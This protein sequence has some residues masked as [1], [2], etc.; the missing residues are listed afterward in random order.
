MKIDELK[1]LAKSFTFAVRGVKNCIVSER[2]MRIHI[3]VAFFTLLFSLF[4]HFSKA[5]MILL[6]LTIAGVISCEMMNTALEAVVDL[7]EPSYNK[8]AQVAKDIAAGAVLVSA[9]AAVVVGV[10][11][12]WNPIIFCE[13]YHFFRSHPP[14][15]LL[16]LLAGAAGLFF[17]FK[18]TSFTNRNKFKGKNS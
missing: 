7:A 15:F 17:I 4:Y 5:E 6:I 14:F 18:G 11:L 10:I 13:I 12:F 16:L 8:I 3:V 1:G 2:N 9:G